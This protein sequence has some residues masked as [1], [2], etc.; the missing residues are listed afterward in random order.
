MSKRRPKPVLR[1]GSLKLSMAD[2]EFIESRTFQIEDIARAFG[3]PPRKLASAAP[4][5]RQPRRPI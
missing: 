1:F 3:V 4:G 2:C 5:A